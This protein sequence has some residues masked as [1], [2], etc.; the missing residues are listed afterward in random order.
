MET[1]NVVNAFHRGGSIHRSSL[2]LILARCR[3]MYRGV[4]FVLDSR[5]DQ[6]SFDSKREERPPVELPARIDGRHTSSG[7]NSRFRHVEIKCSRDYTRSLIGH[8]C[9]RVTGVTRVCIYFLYTALSINSFIR[10]N[11]ALVRK[12]LMPRRVSTIYR[13]V[14]F[15]V[16]SSP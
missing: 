16:I 11:D 7:I 6:S 12:S 8:A 4:C 14:F 5:R 3:S 9:S 13:R 15:Y 2:R 10:E 1:K